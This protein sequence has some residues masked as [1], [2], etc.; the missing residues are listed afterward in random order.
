MAGSWSNCDA[1]VCAISGQHGG[2]SEGP[3]A[4]DQPCALQCR[5]VHQPLA[6]SDLAAMVTPPRNS[7][8]IK[9]ATPN[10][11]PTPEGRS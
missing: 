6:V 4:F 8:M 10:T 1:Q 2:I 11:M 5:A 9:H 7:I 3:K